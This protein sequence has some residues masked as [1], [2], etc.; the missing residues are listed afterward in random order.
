MAI[1]QTQIQN[2]LNANPLQALMQGTEAITA[3]LNNAAAAARQRVDNQ[4]SQDAA[5]VQ[6]MQLAQGLSQRRA[7]DLDQRLIDRRNFDYRA[8]QDAVAND[9]RQQQFEAQEEERRANRGFKQQQLDIQN[10]GVDARFYATDLKEAERRRELDAL[11]AAGTVPPL[12]EPTAANT[13]I[14]PEITPAG[15]VSHTPRA[16]MGRT[17]EVLQSGLPVQGPQQ[18]L[19]QTLTGPDGVTR[20]SPNLLVDAQLNAQPTNPFANFSDAQLNARVDMYKNAEAANKKAGNAAKLNQN[21]EL[22]NQIEAEI[23]R[24]KAEGKGTNVSLSEQRLQRN[25]QLKAVNT[26]ADTLINANLEAFPSQLNMIRE[27]FAKSGSE[28]KDLAK[29]AAQD[30]DRLAQYTAAQAYEK[31]KVQ[32]EMNSA[33]NMRQQEYISKGPKAQAAVRKRIWELANSQGVTTTPAAQSSGLQSLLNAA[34]ISL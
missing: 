14:P 32:S 17:D 20:Q 7:Q 21:I 4:R 27:E 24:R 10:R 5:L 26:E 30:P 1:A 6:N 29:W 34:G 13:P 2:S 22:R 9:L 23:A 18:I 11:N 3:I 16:L 15:Q 25:E 19:S 33:R 8:G 28:E 31:N 12:V